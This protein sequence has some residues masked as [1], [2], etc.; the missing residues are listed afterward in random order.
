[1]ANSHHKMHTNCILRSAVL[2]GFVGLFSGCTGSGLAERFNIFGS[3]ESAL[4]SDAEIER[5]ISN[6]DSPTQNSRVQANSTQTAQLPQVGAA[7]TFPQQQQ[8]QRPVSAQTASAQ[9]ASAQNT[10]YG[11]VQS[12]AAQR[13]VPVLHTLARGESLDQIVQQAPGV[14]LLDF[15][16]DWCGPCRK[17]GKTLHQL[18]ATAKQLG[19][20]IIKVDVDQHK[21]IAQRFQAER[22]PTLVVL[23]KGQTLKRK[24]GLTDSRTLSSWLAL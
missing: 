12:A 7:P 20:T 21:K 15:Y 3:R 8:V 5:E 14:V 4:V 23:K 6:W 9:I 10:A 24:V 16:A 22:L 1:M 17:Q 2:F 13:S 11:N 19:A 18:E